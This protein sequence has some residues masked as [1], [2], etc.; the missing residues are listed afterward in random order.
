MKIRQKIIVL[1]AL[2]IMFLPLTVNAKELSSLKV[3]GID[4][5][6]SSKNNW[7]LTYVSPRDSMVIDATPINSSYTIEGIGRVS[8][9]EGDNTAIVLVRDASGNEIDKYTLNVSFSHTTIS[10]SNSDEKND[11]KVPNPSTGYFINVLPIFIVF[12]I[13]LG[14]LITIKRKKIYKI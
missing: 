14:I 8:L 2:M 4:A 1:G 6:L 3:R 10:S 12:I 7:N 11:G 5:E 9:K 13:S